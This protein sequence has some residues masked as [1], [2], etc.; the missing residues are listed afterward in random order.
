MSNTVVSDSLAE[1][2][3]TVMVLRDGFDGLGTAT[4]FAVRFNF[5]L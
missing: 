5:D 2:G 3:G 1:R 4:G